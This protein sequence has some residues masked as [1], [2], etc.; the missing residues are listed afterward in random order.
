MVS[1][2]QEEFIAEVPLSRGVEVAA[3][4]CPKMVKVAIERLVRDWYDNPESIG[5]L[6]RDAKQIIRKFGRRDWL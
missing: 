5:T 3:Q 2:V 4:L 1:K 6:G